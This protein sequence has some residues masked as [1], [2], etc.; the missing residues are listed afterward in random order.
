M[1]KSRGISGL[2]LCVALLGTVYCIWSALGNDVN[3]CVTSG[4]T[5]YHDFSI[6]GVS[7]WWFGTAA[8]ACLACCALLGQSALG[9]GLSGLFLLGDTLLLLL[10]AVTAPCVSC[11]GAAVLF[12]LS[13]FLFLRAHWATHV[14]QGSQDM[15]RRSLL[16]LVWGVFFVI[17]LGLVARSQI[18]VWPMLDESDNPAVRV[19]FSPSCR[20]CIQAVDALSGKVDVAWYPVADHPGDV[21]RIDRM[22]LLLREGLNMAEALGQSQEA[23][24]KSP[25]EAFRPDILLLQFRMLCNKAHIFIQGSQGVP[26]FEYKGLPPGLMRSNAQV[27]GAL[28]SPPSPRVASDDSREAPWSQGRAGG[29]DA[30]LPS[31]LMEGGQ[32]AEGRPCPPSALTARP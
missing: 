1:I 24:F 5:L 22:I 29:G 12:A 13:Y 11:L 25:W 8:F 20:Y 26:F 17:N 16:L 21:A 23:A 15:P 3:L 32:C 4:C 31:E 7:L 28:G 19:F 10:M 6:A 27:S 14:R 30:S 2:A 18:S 9:R